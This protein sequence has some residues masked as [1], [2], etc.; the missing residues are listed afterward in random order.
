[1][2]V[3]KD[4]LV[5]GDVHG[6]WGPLNTLINKKKPKVVLQ[7][8]DFGWWPKFHNTTMIHSGEYDEVADEIINDPWDRVYIRRIPRKWDQFGLKCQESKIYWCDG[9]HEDHWDLRDERNYMKAPCEVAPGVY[10]MKRGSTLE[11]PD[12]RIVL[13]MGGADSIDK[14]YRKIGFDWF[15]EELITQKDV[16]ELP[17]IHVD[18]VISHTCPK[19]FKPKIEREAGWDIGKYTKKFYDPSTDALSHVLSK[20][21]PGLW[22]F[23]HFHRFIRGEH[24][25]TKWYCL[26]MAPE[27]N[28]WAYLD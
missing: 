15:P 20:Y 17:D 5:V 21:K 13:F 3:S 25:N 27:T 28:W 7:T 8:G 4:I 26:D 11:L 1:M 23:G 10:Y 19:E 9:N 18:I 16:Y 12:G 6:T 14:K 2:P 22:Y 24:D